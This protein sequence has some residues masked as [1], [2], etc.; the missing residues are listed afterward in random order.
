MSLDAF[1]PGAL[2]FGFSDAAEIYCPTCKTWSPVCVVGR[3]AK[4]PQ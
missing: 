1:T 3:C 4:V 2:Q